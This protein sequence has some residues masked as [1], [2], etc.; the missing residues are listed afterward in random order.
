MTT[1][2]IKV[3]GLGVSV[4][5]DLSREAQQALIDAD[6]VFGWQ[7]HQALLSAIVSKNKF[8]QVDA[9]SDLTQALTEQESQQESKQEPKQQ[10]Q[11]ESEKQ[12]RQVVVV[13]SGDPLFYGV[14]KW[15]KL[16]KPESASIGFYPAVSSIQAAC[17]Q[18]GL[19]LQDVKVVSLH[20]RPLL[21]LRPWLKAKAKL[22]VLTDQ[23]SNPN[24]LAQQCAETGFTDSVLHVHENLGGANSRSRCFTVR[25][26]LEKPQLFGDLLV[27]VIEVQGPGW[28]PQAPGIADELF[29]TGA[30]AG[31]GMISKRE[32][33]L[34]ILSYLQPSIGDVIWDVG[35]GCGGVA[36][37]LSYWNP[38]AE[39][40]AVEYQPERLAYLRHNREKFGV[41]KNLTVV[42]GKA[43]AA[44][45][46]LAA[47]SK[48]FVGGSDGELAS[49]LY[50]SWQAL[51]LGGV[52]VGSA[53]IASTKQCLADFCQRLAA[54][55]L[56]DVESV[57]LAVKRGSIMADQNTTS[58]LQYQ[59][60]L[61]VEIFKL[62]KRSNTDIA[63]ALGDFLV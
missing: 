35:A 46:N 57:E 34:L 48:V 11:L 45:K 38:E 39:V 52:L 36:V 27:C 5:A 26:L 54:Q 37:E 3:V 25:E 15:L 16:N 8:V 60:K 17:H 20:G 56:A 9:L 4:P 43:P 42:E 13:A 44:L 29:E 59:A 58:A 28:L 19:S 33:R 10:S 6:V 41:V 51:P 24:A 7:R 40:Q 47:P 30:E 14:G 21:S 50:T 12:P 32:V 55:K 62:V 61:P 2:Q 31:K 53:V 1:L 22:V 23:H 49:I 63:A 18:Q